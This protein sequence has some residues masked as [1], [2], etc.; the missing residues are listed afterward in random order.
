M[1]W[2]FGGQRFCRSA[3]PAAGDD[4]AWKAARL[5]GYEARE[6]GISEAT[7]GVAAVQVLRARK[8]G[9]AEAGVW[10]SH[11]ADVLFHFVLKGGVTLRVEGRDDVQLAA[12]DAFVIPPGVKAAL[13]TPTDELELLEVA[14]PGAFETQLHAG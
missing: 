3:A 6:T 1:N 10:A 8:D 13:A 11:T 5:P 4:A 2:I 7:G 9:R 12:C 14:L